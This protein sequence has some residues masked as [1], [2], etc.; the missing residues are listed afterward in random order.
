MVA[1]RDTEL[2]IEFTLPSGRVGRR[3]RSGRAGEPE[4]AR[5]DA[6]EPSSPSVEPLSP[7]VP[8]AQLAQE[9]NN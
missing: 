3:K 4:I 2:A 7:T 9:V 5:R 8:S 6:A 1:E